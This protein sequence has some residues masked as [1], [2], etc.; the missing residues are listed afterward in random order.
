MPI[1]TVAN[2]SKHPSITSK[3]IKKIQRFIL[4]FKIVG[5]ITKK[6]QKP[7][8]EHLKITKNLLIKKIENFPNER[9]AS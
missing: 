1:K 9:K 3:H 2:V 5:I 6:L 7:V 4:T 8:L